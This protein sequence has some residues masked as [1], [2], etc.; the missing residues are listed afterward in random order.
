ML[1]LVRTATNTGVNQESLD[2]AVSK[3]LPAAL[4]LWDQWVL[5]ELREDQDHLDPLDKK[6]SPATE[7][8]VFTEK[9]AKRVR[10]DCQD[11]MEFHQ[12]TMMPAPGP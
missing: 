11:P 12:T 5:L 7:D 3:G 8:L 4:G 2:W 1:Y 10:W 9:K 6:D